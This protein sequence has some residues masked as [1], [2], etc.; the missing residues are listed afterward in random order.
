MAKRITNGH[1]PGRIQARVKALLDGVQQKLSSS[2]KP[3][4]VAG[5]DNTNVDL[6]N[7]LNVIL[8]RYVAPDAAHQA[9]QV[10]VRARDAAETQ[11]MAQIDAIES[12][13]KNRY[14]ATSPE[15]QAFGMKPRKA[16][17]KLTAQQREAA[18]EKAR[19]TRAEH[20][21]ASGAGVT[22]TPV[23]PTQPPK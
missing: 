12:A 6:A 1:S 8:A 3:L 2:S 10:S 15:L 22:T 13:L 23:Q 17:R 9:W 21:T 16:P 11:D 4:E 14:G 5:V 7:T 18:T 20:E 19:E